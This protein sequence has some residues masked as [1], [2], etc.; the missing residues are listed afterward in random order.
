MTRAAG[1]REARNELGIAIGRLKAIDPSPPPE[2]VQR[3][4][5]DVP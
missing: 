4:L 2:G 1:L 3:W 5:T